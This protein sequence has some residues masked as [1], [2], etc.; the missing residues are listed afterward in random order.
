MILIEFEES[1]RRDFRMF[2]ISNNLLMSVGN[3]YR[4]N[5]WSLIFSSAELIYKNPSNEI[6][7]TYIQELKINVSIVDY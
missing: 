5:A 4:N 7:Y 6:W 2:V 3:V 1:L